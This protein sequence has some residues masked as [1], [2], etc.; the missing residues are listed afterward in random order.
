MCPSRKRSYQIYANGMPRSFNI[1]SEHSSRN[2]SLSC[3]IS[4]TKMTAPSIFCSVSEYPRPVIFA[5]YLEYYFV[6]PQMAYYSGVMIDLQYLFPFGTRYFVGRVSNGGYMSVKLALDNFII[7]Y[8]VACCSY[9]LH[10]SFVVTSIIGNV[11]PGN[12]CLI[13]VL[14]SLILWE[15]SSIP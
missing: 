6:F 14:V 3:F 4:L 9:H 15:N 8:R 11:S 10:G 13:G 5:S 2:T 12:T 1:V 7:S